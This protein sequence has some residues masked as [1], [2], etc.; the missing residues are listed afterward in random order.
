MSNLPTIFEFESR[1]VRTVERDG[2]PWFVA[3]DA[4]VV[5]GIADARQALDKL[6]DDE[7]GGC[8]IP[9]PSGQQE[10]R[11]VNESGLYTLILRCRGATTPGTVPYRFRKWVT[12][13][14]LPAIRK[15]GAYA[16]QADRTELNLRLVAECRETFGV[17]AA[18]GLWRDVG[19]PAIRP[20]FDPDARI[21]HRNRPVDLTTRVAAKIQLSGEDGIFRRNLM[22]FLSDFGRAVHLDG[23]IAELTA[24][25]L[26][27]TTVY[28]RA[29]GGRPST[30]YRWNPDVRRTAPVTAAL[31]H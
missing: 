17:Q 25:K 8:S 31:P 21:G 2:A 29:A 23:A 30:H 28:R 12:S 16:P 5:L 11:V 15:T 1:A 3:N 26:I 4:C 18:R 19:L 14:V 9:T 7:R 27:T 20:S 13:E 6:D 22:R 10:M 24:G